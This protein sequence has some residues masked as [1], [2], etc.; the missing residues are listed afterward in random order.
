MPFFQTFM[1]N[2]ICYVQSWQM[3]GNATQQPLLTWAMLEPIL[4]KSVI[5]DSQRWY[6]VGVGSVGQ[7]ESGTKS[8]YVLYDEETDRIE[9]R[10]I[11]TR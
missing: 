2:S 4:T 7:P 1:G 3:P 9:L 5:T 6:I 8:D 10:T 11:A